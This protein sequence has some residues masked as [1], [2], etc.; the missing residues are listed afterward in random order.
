MWVKQIH[1]CAWSLIDVH[2]V[3]AS[4]IPAN[5]LVHDNYCFSFNICIVMALEQGTKTVLDILENG[6]LLRWKGG[7]E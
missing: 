4:K 3:I 7:E 2:P 1:V 6:K 5:A